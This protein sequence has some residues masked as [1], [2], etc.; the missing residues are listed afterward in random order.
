MGLRCD[1]KQREVGMCRLVKRGSSHSCQSS[2]YHDFHFEAAGRAEGKKHFHRSWTGSA[3]SEPRL[4]GQRE[5][6]GRGGPRLFGSCPCSTT[7]PLARGRIWQ[8]PGKCICW[9]YIQW[10]ENHWLCSILKHVAFTF[11][12]VVYLTQFWGTWTL[13]FAWPFSFSCYC[14]LSFLLYLLSDICSHLYCF[15]SEHPMPQAG[16]HKTQK[17]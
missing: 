12:Q 6:E 5:A 10:M 15:S 17:V 2:S 4:G 13:L 14:N 16:D 1:D 7:L 3:R 8:T 9:L 11:P